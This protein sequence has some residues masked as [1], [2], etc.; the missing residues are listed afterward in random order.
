MGPHQRALL[1]SQ[2]RHPDFLDGEI[3]CMDAEVAARMRPFEAA[4]R[5]L[6]TIPGVG[7]RGA[8]EILAEI[9]PD[10]APRSRFDPAE[11]T[12]RRSGT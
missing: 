5:R 10:G 12:N 8:E 3:A 4:I 1:R 11:Q 6:D 2:L 9:G 7:H